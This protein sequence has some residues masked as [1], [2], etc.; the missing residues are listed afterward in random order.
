MEVKEDRNYGSQVYGENATGTKRGDEV[1]GVTTFDKGQDK[2]SLVRKRPPPAP[3]HASPRGMWAGEWARDERDA[4]RA[5]GTERQQLRRA[6]EATREAGA[7]ARKKRAAGLRAQVDPTFGSEL[8]GEVQVSTIR[9]AAAAPTLCDG[10]TIR[11]GTGRWLAGVKPSSLGDP[12]AGTGLHVHPGRPALCVL[13]ESNVQFDLQAPEVLEPKL[14]EVGAYAVFD[15]GATKP[16]CRVAYF[17]TTGADNA[18]LASAAATTLRAVANALVG[19]E[20]QAD[21]RTGGCYAVG[22]NA[23]MQSTPEVTQ[24]VVTKV[25]SLVVPYT[26][27]DTFLSGVKECISAVAT[28]LGLVADRLHT[29][30]PEV[31]DGLDNPAVLAGLVKDNKEPFRNALRDLSMFPSHEAQRVGVADPAGRD[32][33]GRSICCHQLAMRL[34]GEPLG[35][36]ADSD[37][38]QRFDPSVQ[39][40][41]LHTDVDDA[42]R[43]NGPPLI[44]F[45]ADDAADAEDAEAEDED[46]QD[47]PPA[48]TRPMRENDLVVFGGAQGGRAVRIQTACRN[49]VCVV[50]FSSAEHMHGNVFPDEEEGEVLVP[51]TA[52]RGTALLRIVPYCRNGI[53]RYME[54][55]AE[56]PDYLNALRDGRLIER[57]DTLSPLD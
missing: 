54:Q 56:T 16:Y 43:A 5:A 26:R 7:P 22:G 36:N 12:I 40:C 44:Y 3:E 23:V 19:G 29:T 11:D 6:M 31:L 51:P 39:L 27:K 35:V 47:A 24:R 57:W 55:A 2:V 4:W 48:E 8:R 21:E 41:A 14:G 34:A 30:F 13:T 1:V 15:A 25:G 9:L 28:V 42:R 10:T 18:P 45:Y 32:G 37:C 52:T 50:S 38:K 46:H 49:H 20:S 17:P 53:D 33:E